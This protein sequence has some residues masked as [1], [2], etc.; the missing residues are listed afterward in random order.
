MSDPLSPSANRPTRLPPREP[1]GDPASSR[2]TPRT[3]LLAV[4]VPVLTLAAAGVVAAALWAWWADPPVP[5]DVTP[6]N[7]E[8]QLGSLFGVELRY[9]ALAL[10]LGGVAGGALTVPLRRSGW[11]LVVGMAAGGAVAAAVS[12]WLGVWWGPSPAAGSERSDLLSGGLVLTADGLFLAWPVAALA[13]CW[14]VSWWLD[15]DQ[16]ASSGSELPDLPPASAR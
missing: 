15:R 13:G 14:F 9:A 12:Y 5:A 8:L 2:P 10:L 3:L 4:L 6:E 1:C 16:I 11:V 7:V